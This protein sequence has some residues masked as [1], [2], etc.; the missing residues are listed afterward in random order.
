[1]RRLRETQRNSGSGD[2]SYVVESPDKSLT[3]DGA[4]AP[5]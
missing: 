3:R 5:G 4:D 1:M 2:E